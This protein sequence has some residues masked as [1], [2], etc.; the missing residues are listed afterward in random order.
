MTKRNPHALPAKR[1][2]GAGYHKDSRRRLREEADQK[3]LDRAIEDQECEIEGFTGYTVDTL[4]N[5]YGPRFDK[6]LAT[7]LNSKG[8]RRVDLYSAPGKRSRF[9]VH[10]LVA[11]AFIPNPENKP[12]VNHIN[13]IP[14]DNRVENL[15]WVTHKENTQHAYKQGLLSNRGEDNYNSRITEEIAIAALTSNAPTSVVAKNL[16][17]SW[18]DIYDIRNRRRWKHVL[19]EFT[20]TYKKLK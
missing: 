8:Y 16:G 2:T 12:C 7:D 5:V 18:Q 14:T 13:G 9:F 4:G 19:P 6:P 1:R 11:E 10:R 15:E 20:P 17:V 3:D